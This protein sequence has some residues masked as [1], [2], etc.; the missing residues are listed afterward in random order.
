MSESSEKT[1]GKAKRH[2][3]V[4]LQTASD[5][6][7]LLAKMINGTLRDEVSSDKLRAISYATSMLLKSV[8]LGELTDR[9]EKIER[10]I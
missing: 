5:I 1:E 10:R 9:L 8:E 3:G 6:R 2:R 4:R 7:R